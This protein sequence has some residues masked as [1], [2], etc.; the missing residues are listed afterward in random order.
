MRLFEDFFP[1]RNIPFEISYAFS[2]EFPTT[3]LQ[4]LAVPSQDAINS[5]NYRTAY[6][7]VFKNLLPSSHWELLRDRLP[8]LIHSSVISAKCPGQAT[9]A[10]DM[11]PEGLPSHSHLPFPVVSDTRGTM[12][13][14]S[15]PILQFTVGWCRNVP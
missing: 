5:I 11:R 4:Q 1:D 6:T 12:L 2:K 14:T 9:E 10:P 7:L 3:L 8:H 13:Y 15:K